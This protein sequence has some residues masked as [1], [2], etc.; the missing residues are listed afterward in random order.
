MIS[1]TYAPLIAFCFFFVLVPIWRFWTCIDRMGFMREVG[2][3]APSMLHGDII[4]GI[5]AFLP[6][7]LAVLDWTGVTLPRQ[8]GPISPYAAVFWAVVCVVIASIIMSRSADRFAAHWAGARE[9][10][11]RTVAVLRIIDAAE[12]A[13]ALDVAQQH[14]AR[15]G[16]GRVIDAE[17]R[18]VRK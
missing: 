5:F 3:R 7:M 18:G 9:S 15:H 11:L 12:L 1:Y 6:F 10:A 4:A 8:E 13:H 2:R 17:T 14:E 16:S